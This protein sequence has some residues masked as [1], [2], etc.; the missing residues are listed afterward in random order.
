MNYLTQSILQAWHTLALSAENATAI[1]AKLLACYSEPHRHY[2]TLQHLTECLASLETVSNLAIHPAE[3]AIALWF[4]DAIYDVKRQDNEL[5]SALWA[6][7][8]V[9]A[10][11]AALD[12]AERIYA[13]VMATRH[14]TRPQTVDEQLLVDID[15]SIFGADTERFEEYECQIRQEYLWVPVE[16]FRTKRLAVLQEFLL[17]PEIY[18]T[19]FFHEMLESRARENLQRSINHLS[20]HDK[21]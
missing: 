16:E 15:L 18:A 20:T 9:I 11:G 4:H 19:P 14:R 17:R 2:H 13:L 1:Q 3:V 10:Y 12:V 8:T 5:Q 21:G 6:K 7:Q